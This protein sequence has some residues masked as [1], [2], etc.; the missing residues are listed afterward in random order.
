M[1][2]R[3]FCFWL[4]GYF[5]I[6]RADENKKGLPLSHEQVLVISK[7]LDSVFQAKTTPPPEFKLKEETSFTD[8]TNKMRHT[9]ITA[10][11]GGFIP[12]LTVEC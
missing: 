3:D 12:P 11:P 10:P 2:P 8:F 5:E 9:F 4:Q 1:T 7:H 6:L